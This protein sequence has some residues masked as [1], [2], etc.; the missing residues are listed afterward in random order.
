MNINNT[1]SVSK[2]HNSL[3]KNADVYLEEIQRKH[4]HH[5]RP[6]T[7]SQTKVNPSKTENKKIFDNDFSFLLPEGYEKVFISLYALT[8][9]YLAGLVFL[10]F[11][12]SKQDLSIFSSI[13]DSHSALFTWCIGYEIVAVLL[14]IMLIK[15]SISIVGNSKR[16]QL[17]RP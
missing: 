1:I 14:L 17:Q 3:L 2:K 13:C 9:P 8:L 15:Q 11:Y 4:K 7:S 12:I 16:T 10:F 5:A 6:Y